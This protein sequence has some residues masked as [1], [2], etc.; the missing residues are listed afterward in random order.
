[1]PSSSAA[2]AEDL[3]RPRNWRRVDAW[4]E[5]EV[6]P[7]GEAGGLS[8]NYWSS[9]AHS[10]LP[11][12]PDLGDCLVSRPKPFRLVI[13]EPLLT[14]SPGPHLASP[15]CC[16]INTVIF[17]HAPYRVSPWVKLYRANGHWHH[18]GSPGHFE[19][20]DSIE[21]RFTWDERV[22]FEGDIFQI[23]GGS[24]RWA[25]EAGKPRRW[26]MRRSARRIRGEV[27]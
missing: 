24:V 8:W 5:C 15:H 1:M 23:G 4:H 16:Y 13:W 22:E 14:K 18:N 25:H 27:Q 7:C 20:W 2:H 11:R 21:T 17:Y 19:E 26:W 6:A 12:A 9:I 10:E 3:V